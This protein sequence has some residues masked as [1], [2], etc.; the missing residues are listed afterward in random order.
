M[1]FGSIFVAS[2]TTLSKKNKRKW[3]DTM[4]IRAEIAKYSDFSIL[5]FNFIFVP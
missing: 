1:Q 4:N 3:Q 2:S 5:G